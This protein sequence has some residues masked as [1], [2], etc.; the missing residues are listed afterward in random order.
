M[1]QYRDRDGLRRLAHLLS[2]CYDCRRPLQCFTY[3]SAGGGM[4]TVPVARRCSCASQAAMRK[5][6]EKEHQPSPPR[7]CLL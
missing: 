3:P 6:A 2:L 7:S 4:L 5:R 1:G